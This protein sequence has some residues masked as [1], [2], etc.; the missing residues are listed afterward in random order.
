[1]FTI[2]KPVR[3]R[4]TSNP[5]GKLGDWELLQSLAS[6]LTSPNILIHFSNEADRAV[7]DFAAYTASTYRL[8]TRKPIGLDWKYEISGLDLLLK[9]K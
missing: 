4:E 3:T 1:M 7:H 8:W 5:V 2:T 9:H 6:E